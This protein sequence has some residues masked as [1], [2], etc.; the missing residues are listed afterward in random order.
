MSNIGD[1]IVYG[2][3]YSKDNDGK[4]ISIYLI[5]TVEN[6]A[7]FIAKCPP[8]TSIQICNSSDE[9]ILNTFGNFLNV[10]NDQEYRSWIINTLI[11]MQTGEQ[12][13]L[14][15]EFILEDELEMSKEDYKNWVLEVTGYEL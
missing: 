3:I 14:D 11:D 6:I 4:Y 15:I 7:S 12:D 2:N 9:L 8:F 13:P 1:K 10:C 5:N